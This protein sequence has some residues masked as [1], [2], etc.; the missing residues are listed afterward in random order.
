MQMLLV[1]KAFLQM[2]RILC[3]AL[4]LPH[5]LHWLSD[6]QAPAAFIHIKQKNML[7]SILPF[8][9]AQLLKTTSYISVQSIF[10]L[11]QLHFF[12]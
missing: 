6:T 12:F 11:S 1:G 8:P 3:A 7:S 5:H 2:L 9:N 10:R 4:D